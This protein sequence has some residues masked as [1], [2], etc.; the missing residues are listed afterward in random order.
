MDPKRAVQ[1]DRSVGR[2]VYFLH[3]W[4]YTLT[5]G[6]V[7]HKTGT[8][9]ILLLTTTGRRSGR[10]RTKPL[11]YMSDGDRYV[12]VASNGGRD[13][14]PSWFL[15]LTARPEAEVQVGRRSV[16][17]TAEVLSGPRRSEIWPRLREFYSGWEHY[18][19]LTERQLPVVVLSPR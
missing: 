13:Q 1:L 5:G 19:H 3:R 8:G 18:S 4:V 12:V 17:V 2:Q 6:V 16:P 15:N 9:P 11:L 7:G 14:P 10:A